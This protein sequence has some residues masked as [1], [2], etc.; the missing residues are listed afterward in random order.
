MRQRDFEALA[1][2]LRRLA[3]ATAQAMLCNGAAAEDVAQDAM[4]KLWAVHD[5]LRG[6]AHARR[7]AHTAARQLAI[8][9]LRHRQRT[10]ALIV[11]IDGSA[12]DN[13]TPPDYG[14]I[15]PQKRMEMEEDERWLRH[16]IANLPTREMQ[17]MEMRQGEG[18]S[19]D[20]I[21][22]IRGIAPA[23][24]AT[25]LSAARRKIFE[26]LKKRNGK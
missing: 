6:E 21:A 23:S 9:F 24:V 17:V 11:P 16:R 1:A 5:E 7:L 4:L 10:S 19:N 20:E 18:K 13:Y 14:D 25:M 26:E 2:E 8:D 15:S 22:R 3:L 12:N